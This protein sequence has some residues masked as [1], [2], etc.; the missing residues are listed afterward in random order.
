MMCKIK[1]VMYGPEQALD[2]VVTFI[3]FEENLL[4]RQ[5]QYEDL[6]R[7]MSQMNVPWE[8]QEVNRA[9]S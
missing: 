9:P 4:S 2:I 3:L 5:V 6:V 1:R 7:K 8:L